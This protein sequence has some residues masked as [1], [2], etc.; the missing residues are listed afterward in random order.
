MNIIERSS[1]KTCSSREE[2][3]PFCGDSR[4]AALTVIVIFLGDG[5]VLSTATASALVPLSYPF[6]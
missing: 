2:V 6:S 4:P 3:L 5:D 1:E